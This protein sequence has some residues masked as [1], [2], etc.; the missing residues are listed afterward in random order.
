ML[1]ARITRQKQLV[2][3]GVV[4]AASLQD[5]EIE[6][7]GLWARRKELTAA[8]SEPEALVAPV[9]G[10]I[11]EVR[12]VAGQVVST[13]DTLFNIVDPASLW[14]E[15][16]S[17]DPN[18]DPSVTKAQARTSDGALFDLAFVGRS[19]TL[20]RQATVLQFRLKAP[21]EALSIGSPVKVLIEKGDTITGL[22]L[23]RSAIAQ[24]PNGQ[25]VAFKR[26]EPERYLPVA[27]RITDLD[28][29]RVIAAAGLKPGDQIIVEG[30]SLV[31]QIR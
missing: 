22:I 17:F 2:E 5:L 9:D 11:A 29:E 1:E 25:M 31:N 23:P 4:N 10:V 7:D 24:A 18:I 19:R 8:R 15:A 26:I 16:I 28:G 6:K 14:V 27:I 13:A 30:A 3:K 20:Q 12:V 21:N